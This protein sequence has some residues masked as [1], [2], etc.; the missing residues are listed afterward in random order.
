MRL[1]EFLLLDG[2]LQNFFCR[3]VHAIEGVVDGGRRI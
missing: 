2:G 1:R 3:S